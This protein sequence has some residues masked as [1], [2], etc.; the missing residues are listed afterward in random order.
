MELAGLRRDVAHAVERY[1]MSERR[2]CKLVGIERM[3]YRYEPRPDHNAELREELM[4]LARQKP[5]WGYRRLHIL[6]ERRGVI[7]SSQRVYRVYRKDGL[8]VRRLRRK[9]Y[10]RMHVETPL[11]SRPNQEW[12]MDFVHDA[13]STG[14]GMR[15][16][17]I[18]DG[19]TRESPA[20][21]VHTS[22]GSRMITRLLDRLIEERGKPEAIRCDNGPEFTSRHLLAWCEEHGI[23]LAH[24]Q[25]GRPMQNGYNESF[26]GRLRDECLNAHCFHNLADARQKIEAWRI[27]YNAE[28]PHSSLGYRTP[29]EFAAELAKQ[30]RGKDARQMPGLENPL[31]FPLSHR[32]PAAG[33]YQP[34]TNTELSSSPIPIG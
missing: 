2:A 28:R 26:N 17:T 32:R 34:K 16:L 10:L 8:A 19:F 5:R 21:L 18:V 12:A 4:I 7:A 1:G 14:R 6:L 15:T 23:Q 27:E 25:P 20:L 11:L 9:R 31:G 29:N 30:G 33:I 3:S 24:I 22:I 13:L